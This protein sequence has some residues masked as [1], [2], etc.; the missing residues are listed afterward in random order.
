MADKRSRSSDEAW[1]SSDDR[2]GRVAPLVRA[3]SKGGAER[4]E[5]WKLAVN[6]VA[7]WDA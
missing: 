2:G 4:L 6:A 7:G 5:R 1:R 3:K